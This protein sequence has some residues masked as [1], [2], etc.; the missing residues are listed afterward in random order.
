MI[1]IK[2]NEFLVCVV[3]SYVII[4][5]LNLR[6]MIICINEVGKIIDMLEDDGFSVIFIVFYCFYENML[7]DIVVLDWEEV[8]VYMII[9]IFDGFVKNK[10]VG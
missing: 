4:R 9:I 1:Y 10:Y 2:W 6:C 7:G 8:E 5:N 3:D